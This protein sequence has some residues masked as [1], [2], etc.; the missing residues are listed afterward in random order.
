MAT[1][2]TI[3]DSSGSYR[4]TN[5][6]GPFAYGAYLYVVTC[7]GLTGQVLVYRSN[8][9]GATWSLYDD[10]GPDNLISGGVVVE[11]GVC[12]DGSL[13]RVAYFP[14]GAGPTWEIEHSALDLDTGT[15]S[16]PVASGET[17]TPAGPIKG[18]LWAA[19]GIFA[20]YTKE[21]TSGITSTLTVVQVFN[22]STWS[23][24]QTIA[25][26]SAF[27]TPQYCCT[28]ADGGVHLGFNSSGQHYVKFSDL[29]VFGTV[30]SASTGN[31]AIAF[32][33]GATEYLCVAFVSGTLMRCTIS[34]IADPTTWTTKTIYTRDA[35]TEF[36]ISGSY[37][38]V[39]S[40]GSLH[41]FFW[42]VQTDSSQKL[43]KS[44]LPFADGGGAW[45][46][47]TEIAT[48]S[49]GDAGSSYMTG[50]V[51]GSQARIVYSPRLV[52]ASNYVRYLN[53]TLVGCAGCCCA[54]YAY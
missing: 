10:T 30:Y 18:C 1:I 33:S 54:D 46:T 4:P 6:Y 39:R 11:M 17:V 34:A 22:G 9:S 53:E 23:A 31:S 37:A 20:A 50:Y 8:D 27:S 14:D 40:G 15:W 36:A 48:Q 32:T 26:G 13:L 25:S 3:V 5:S 21:F 28:A 49:S 16:S 41:C 2:V 24:A 51:S 43:R 29:E 12:L 38:L 42:W 47:P 35:G 45:S 7:D 52:S 44:C 19:G